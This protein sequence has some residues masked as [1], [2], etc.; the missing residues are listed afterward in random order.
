MHVAF[1]PKVCDYKTYCFCCCFC[2][3]FFSNSKINLIEIVFHT[4]FFLKKSH[5][6]L[7]PMLCKKKKCLNRILAPKLAIFSCYKYKSRLIS[8]YMGKISR[9]YADTVCS[10]GTTS[11]WQQDIGRQGQQQ[12]VKDGDYKPIWNDDL[13]TKISADGLILV[14]QWILKRFSNT[15][16]NFFIT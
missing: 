6:K 10:L 8:L 2:Y 3:F 14:L 15:T 5:K 1:Q 12:K 7:L 4:F 13:W 9:N 11:P 16:C